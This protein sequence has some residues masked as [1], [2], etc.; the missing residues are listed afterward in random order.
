MI[1]FSKFVSDG[2]QRRGKAENADHQSDYIHGFSPPLN[3]FLL[4]FPAPV[5]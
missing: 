2:K 3:R 4:P 5:M 1:I